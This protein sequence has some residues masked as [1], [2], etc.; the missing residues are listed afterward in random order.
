MRFIVALLATLLLAPAAFADGNDR[1]DAYGDKLLTA[2]AATF[3]VAYAPMTVAGTV[4]SGLTGGEPYYGGMFYA[5]VASPFAWTGMF[6]QY[7]HGSNEAILLGTLSFLD[8]AAQVV[9][10]GLM[11]GGSVH[12]HR[13]AARATPTLSLR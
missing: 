5:P 1:K 9:G 4:F 11:I 13:V 2:G 7:G 8:G 10:I 6:A 12:R 3:T